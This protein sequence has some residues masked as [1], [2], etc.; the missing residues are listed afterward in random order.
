MIGLTYPAET[1]MKLLWTNPSPNTSFS[2]QTISLNLSSYNG[3]ILSANNSY[4]GTNYQ[5]YIICNI[6][7]SSAIFG[8]APNGGYESYSCR[9]FN[10]TETGVHFSNC[11]WGGNTSYNINAIPY[12][13]FGFKFTVK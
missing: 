8:N 10:I 5:T 9:H 1:K 7:E 3:I 12:K 6:G 4:V 2:E 13:I 11:T